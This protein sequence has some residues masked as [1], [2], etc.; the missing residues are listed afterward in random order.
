MLVAKSGVY[1]GRA[2]SAIRLFNTATATSPPRRQDPQQHRRQLSRLRNSIT[3]ADDLAHALAIRQQGRP[4]RLTDLV[5]DLQGSGMAGAL[6]C[7]C[8]AYTTIR[9]HA[10]AEIDRSEHQY[11]DCESAVA[12]QFHQGA[13][14][15]LM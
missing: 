3:S 4:P 5:D 1:V 13:G 10:L 15:Q 6:Q 12:S 14:L 8:V 11:M 7:L 2:L 9:H